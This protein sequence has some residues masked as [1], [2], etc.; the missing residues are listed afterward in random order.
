MRKTRLIVG[1]AVGLAICAGVVNGTRASQGTA[2]GVSIDSDDLG[3]P[4]PDRPDRRR[5]C[6]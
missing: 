5:A 4:S 6:G 1:I 2:A 3:A